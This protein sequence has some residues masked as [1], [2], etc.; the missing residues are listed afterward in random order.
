MAISSI[1]ILGG[2]LRQCYTAEYLHNLGWKVV[3]Y[4]TPD[5]PY[6]PGIIQEASLSEAVRQTNISLMPTP[7]SKDGTSLFQTDPDQP[8]CQLSE[9]WEYS[10]PGQAVATYDIPKEGKRL[11]EQKGCPVFCYSQSE[12]F[13]TENA[14][15]TA[16]GLLSELIRNTPFSLSNCSILLLGYGYCGFAIASLLQPICRN[17]FVLEQEEE[18]QKLAETH[19][20]CP[21][22]PEDFPM[23]LPQCNIV[24]NTI[25]SQLLSSA[26]LQKL[27]GTCHVFDIASAPFGFRD[28]MTEET[29]IPYFRLPGIPGRYAPASSGQAIGKIIERMTDYVL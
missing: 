24:I 12:T 29:Q 18:K 14:R 21:I 28:C 11:L 8:A 17:I 6:P 22:T 3:C 5:F 27:P 25:P 1:A 4:H 10:P 16:E 7:L 26:H 23:I 20:V 13:R 2:D 9:L 19:G 15:L